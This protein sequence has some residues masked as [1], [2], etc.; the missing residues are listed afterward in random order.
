MLEL[1]SLSKS[2]GDGGG[3]D[4]VC[5]TVNRGEIVSLLGPSGCGKSTLLALIAGLETP[6]AG[7]VR[8]DGESLA[9]LPPHRRSF[10]LMFQDYALFPHRDV[11]DNV[12]FGLRMQNA[13]E[14]EVALRVR[15]ALALVNLS[16]FERR[17][18][19]TLS[20]GEAQRI[21]LA[22]SL[23]PRPRLLMLDEPLGALDRTLRD[24]L[25]DE[26]RGML[27]AFGGRAQT[28]LYVTH[29]QQEAF[30]LADR[31]ALMNAG[32]IVQVGAPEEVYNSPASPFV[33]RFLGLTNL[34]EA[35]PDADSAFTTAIGRFRLTSRASRST[36]HASRLTLLL[37]PDCAR[38]SGS[39]NRLRVRI[40]ERSFRG[41]YTRLLTQPERGPH[42]IFDFPPQPLPQVG[43]TVD[44]FLDPERITVLQG[45]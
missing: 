18:V 13:P 3:L 31:V 24:A 35:A 36:P 15:E 4:D 23:C 5:L 28:A 22:R 6:D 39:A 26:L 32:R 37:R 21:A 1:V 2:F 38:L 8:W 45:E 44:L 12:A 16:G 17:D 34:V 29:D 9:G 42:L 25:L 41:V 43:E 7:E 10:G 14:T 27:R 40:L 19:N 33:A 11:F 30:A 20:G